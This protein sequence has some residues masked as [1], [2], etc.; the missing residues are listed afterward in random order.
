LYYSYSDAQGSLIALVHDGGS[1]IQRFAYDPWGA[2]RDPNNWNVKDSR[3]S[4]IINRGYTGHEHLDKFGIINMN[5][6]VYDPATGMFLSPDPTLTDAG[7]WL[8]YNRYSYCLNNPFKYTDPSGFSWWAESWQSVVTTFSQIVVTSVVG[9]L[10]AGLGASAIIASGMLAGAA[11]GFTGGAIGTALYGGSFSDAMGAGIKGA[12]FGAFSGAITAGIGVQFGDVGG[13]VN[14]LGRTG[15]HGLTQGA[16][17]ALRGGNFWQGAA[18]GLFS[19]FGGSVSGAFG[20][21]G[22]FGT[23][24]VSSAMGG[25]GAAI[26]GARNT[27]DI[28]FGMAAGAMVGA[29]NHALHSLLLKKREQAYDKM[30]ELSENGSFHE[31]ACFELHDGNTLILPEQGNDARN[32]NIKYYNLRK[33]SKGNPIITIK[34]KTYIVDNVTHVHMGTYDPQSTNPIYFS[35]ED[36]DFSNWIGKP[37]KILMDGHLFSTDSQNY[38]KPK[39]I[40]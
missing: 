21:T 3:T 28:L 8:D 14:E 10:T 30:I 18:A 27:E 35:D 39:M 36:G 29:L 15:A 1:V 31:V 17:S 5:G 7:N 6:R 12:V 13:I 24:A 23:V 9:I 22:F 11:G 4:F 19:S 2:R 26:G 32:A 20:V 25:V 16:F 34:G 33:D 37:I 38:M 40:W